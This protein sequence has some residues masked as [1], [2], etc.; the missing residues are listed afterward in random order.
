MGIKYL[1]KFLQDNCEH[2][3]KKIHMNNLKNK[4]IVID[5]S[6]YLYK[7]KADGLLF[8]NMF[9]LIS[10]LRKN[11]ISPL[12]VFDGK[13]PEEK[14]EIIK[15]RKNNKEVAREEYNKYQEKLSSITSEEEKKEIIDNMGSLKRQFI[16]ISKKNIETV[17]YLFQCFGVSYIDAPGE[18]DILCAKL[19]QKNKAYACLSEDMDMFAYGCPRVLRYLSL[20]HHTIVMYDTQKILHQLDMSIDDFR[21]IC[22]LSG[23]D[24]LNIKDM[25]LYK[26]LKFYKKYRKSDYTDFNVYI[27]KEFTSV[28]YEDFIKTKNIFN[29]STNKLDKKYEKIKIVN[30]DVNVDGLKE[31]MK[32]DNFIFVE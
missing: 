2:S 4:K 5:T 3:I 16:R 19:V 9:L 24:Y 20:N 13:P 29:L 31:L 8:E 18:A 27:D 1:N 10:I 21:C 6:I 28:S 26:V 7:F 30:S 32:E 23:N 12:F 11:N 17:K 14:N 15:E 22:V 25:N